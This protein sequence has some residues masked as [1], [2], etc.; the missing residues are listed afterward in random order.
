MHWEAPP[1][2][3]R[4]LAEEV[5]VWRVTLD[6]APLAVTRGWGQLA[7]EERLRADRFRFATHRDRFV[8]ARAALRTVLSRYL[9]TT[10]EALR[11][12]QEPSGKPVLRVPDPE[13]LQFNLAHSA[14]LALI[15]VARGRAVGVDLERMRRDLPLRRI[16]ARFLAPGEVAELDAVPARFR[17]AAF[18]STWTR[19][20]AYL[21]AAGVGGERGLVAGLGQFAVSVR[22][23]PGGPAL[24]LSGRPA[25]ST[26]WSLVDLAAGRGF[27]AALAVEGRA[28]P[29]TFDLDV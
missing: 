23:G 18:F 17:P 14:D 25:E 21:K 10:P 1:D 20:E 28:R 26:R 24:V 22:P 5:H 2:P 12:G 29:R 4:L 19:K 27:A 3:L 15:A 7:P 6:R 11:F 8:L 13:A 16:A 9:A